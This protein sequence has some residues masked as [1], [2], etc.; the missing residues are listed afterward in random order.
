MLG[1]QNEGTTILVVSHNLDSI[2]RVCSRVL[3]LNRGT[4]YFEGTADEGISHYHDL[5]RVNWDEGTQGI[6][7]TAIGGDPEAPI[8]ITDIELLD[9]NSSRTA[10]FESGSAM[11]VRLHFRARRTV[12]NPIAG[13][14]LSNKANILVYRSGSTAYESGVFD[15]GAHGQ[16]DIRMNLH[17][18]AGTYTI[19]SWMGWGERQIEHVRA[20]AQ[21]FYVSSIYRRGV[22]NLGAEYAARRV[23][24]GPPRTSTDSPAAAS[25]PRG[26]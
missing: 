16:F 10:N 1:L 25:D 17:L 2:R 13:F 6:D 5:L 21:A 23:D 26:L 7:E 20:P 15:E 8:E 24:A 9:A 22:A 11:T 3:V 14:W 19:G 12:K 4:P 18:V